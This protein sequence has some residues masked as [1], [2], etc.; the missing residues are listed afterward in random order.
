[1][2]KVNKKSSCTMAKRLTP[3]LSSLSSST[4]FGL[5]SDFALDPTAH[6]SGNDI[7]VSVGWN[8]LTLAK[9]CN[10]TPHNT[11]TSSRGPCRD[12][13]EYRELWNN[14]LRGCYNYKKSEKT[15][16]ISS[17]SQPPPRV[18]LLLFLYE[19]WKVNWLHCFSLRANSEVKSKCSSLL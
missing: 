11:T 2:S 5:L 13:L 3:S 17:F 19:M 12:S 15:I 16:A 8:V 14:T 1:M 9:W 6:G 18:S 7:E 10:Q 4:T